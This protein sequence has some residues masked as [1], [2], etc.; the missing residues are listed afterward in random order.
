MSERGKG[1]GGDKRKTPCRHRGGQ[2]V[3]CTHDCGSGVGGR[4]AE[5][6]FMPLVSFGRPLQ[7]VHEVVQ[8]ELP[9]T[10]E[11][12]GDACAEKRDRVLTAGG[13]EEAGAVRGQPRDEHREREWDG[14]EA[15]AEAEE[16]Q[17]PAKTFRGGRKDGGE[18]RQR[19]AELR[20]G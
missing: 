11:D 10:G 4:G 12:E 6:G 13:E 15:G 16:Q 19:D 1:R 2:G 18:V 17:K 8:C 7:W 14:G 9:G 3:S 20:E 5:A